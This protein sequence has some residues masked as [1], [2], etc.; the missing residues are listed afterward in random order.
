MAKDWAVENM[1]H[2]Q[3]HLYTLSLS[4]EDPPGHLF[5]HVLEA[6]QTLR[7]RDGRQ[8]GK[9]NGNRQNIASVLQ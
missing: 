3:E 9:R 2:V 4:L 1:E 8:T 6:R 7:Q 5:K